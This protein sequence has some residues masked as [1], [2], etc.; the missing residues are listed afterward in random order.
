MLAGMDIR[1]QYGPGMAGR[2]IEWLRGLERKRF[3]SARVVSDFH[4]T[5]C[6]LRA[7]PDDAAVLAEVERM[8]AGFRHRADLERFAEKLSD[9]GIAG[10]ETRYRFYAETAFWLAQR[11]P[12]HLI[13]DWAEVSPR[14]EA[15]LLERL[16]LIAHSAEIPALDEAA[17][18]LRQWVA[19]MK[20]P[21]EGDG[22]FLARGFG[23]IKAEPFL[24]QAF[25]DEI[26]LPL[27][28]RA[29]ADAP[30]RTSAKHPLPVHWQEVPLR[31]G[32]PDLRAAL[33]QRPRVRAVSE[34]EGSELI[35]LAREAMVTRQRDLDIFMYGD[36]RDV[37][38]LDCGE[39]LA[40]AMIGFRPERRLLLEAVYGFLTLKNGVPIG[41]VLNSAFCGSAEIAYNVFETYRGAEAGHV[42]AWVLACV[43][44]LFRVDAFTIYPYQLG[45]DNDEALD[46]GA[47]WFYQKFG[48]RPRDAGALA[49][50]RREIDR[51][52]KRPGHRSSRAT[53]ARLADHNM[54]YFVGAPRSDV[55]GEIPLAEIGL[56]ATD[57]LA[58]DRHGDHAGEAARRF[59][60]RSFA[61][62]RRDERAAW[63][64]WSPLL[65]LAEG[66]ER[67]S[68]A[69][70]RAAVAAVRAKGGRRESDFVAYF[71]RH[72]KLRAAILKLG[73]RA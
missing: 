1:M 13:V 31:S 16:P 25:Y 3:A 12:E 18:S 41:Y 27:R 64:R 60:L 38:L 8:L 73:E 26:D 6:F 21:G 43:R 15:L 37:R 9:S 56:A 22:A 50:M 53:L 23:A 33:R 62:W 36:P 5:L 29:A 47:W 7:Y 35:R 44:H 57:F 45:Q 58:K 52:R 66:V 59:G 54:F 51:M 19:R 30:S 40:F 65:L 48:F 46:S 63:R 20:A 14:Q 17:L 28:L 72:R 2:K 67:W 39:G 10:T 71:D 24:K 68:P 42:Y 34:R 69:E 61:G 11:H 32:R 55:M 70:R 49:L 4:E